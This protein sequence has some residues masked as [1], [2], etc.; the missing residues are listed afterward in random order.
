MTGRPCGVCGAPGRGFLGLRAPGRWSELPAR[1]RRY[2]WHCNIPDCV[3]EAEARRAKALHMPE[4][5]GH[6]PPAEVRPPKLPAPAPAQAG[7]FGD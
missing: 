3:A 6:A 1:F 4:P 7:L 2:L 5:R